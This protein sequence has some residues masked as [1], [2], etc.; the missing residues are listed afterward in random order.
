[1]RIVLGGQTVQDAATTHY[2]QKVFRDLDRKMNLGGDEVRLRWAG[3]D[4]VAVPHEAIEARA[5]YT[6]KSGGEKTGWIDEAIL[7]KLEEIANA[8]G[9]VCAR[10]LQL[11]HLG[12]YR[13]SSEIVHGTYCGA[14]Y[15]LGNSA[16]RWTNA[17]LTARRGEMMEIMTSSLVHVTVELIKV[18]GERLGWADMVQKA[19]D[20]HFVYLQAQLA[21]CEARVEERTVPKPPRV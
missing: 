16:I 7:D 10:H 5:K 1:M 18:V 4:E 9:P 14:L 11:A 3:L 12:I 19:D 17:A 20:S 21:K 13:Q 6:H 2:M 15:S 8:R